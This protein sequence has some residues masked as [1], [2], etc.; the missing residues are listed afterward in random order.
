MGL[1]EG[2]AWDVKGQTA[3]RCRVGYGKKSNRSNG[4]CL[5]KERFYF[6]FFARTILYTYSKARCCHPKTASGMW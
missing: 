1:V 6:T 3:C 5:L 4:D 2:C